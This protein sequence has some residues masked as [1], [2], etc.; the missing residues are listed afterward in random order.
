[1]EIIDEVYT[2]VAMRELSALFK[3]Y[4]T[5]KGALPKAQGAELLA[6]HEAIVDSLDGLL[7]ELGEHGFDNVALMDVELAALDLER[8]KDECASSWQ[9]VK[10][11]RDAGLD[12]GPLIRS[13][14]AG[15]MDPI[16]S[17]GWQSN[18]R[19]GV[20]HRSDPAWVASLTER[21]KNA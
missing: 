3:I 13:Y 15:W 11:L 4:E 7:T 14:V 6:L 16:G 1:M 21:I 17:L 19:M 12:S 2:L 9:E 5:A 20:K 10:K 8:L 18:M